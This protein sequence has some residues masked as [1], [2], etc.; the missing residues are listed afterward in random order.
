MSFLG[1]TYIQ[2]QVKSLDYH[3]K[4][5]SCCGCPANDQNALLQYKASHRIVAGRMIFHCW[6]F[7][8]ITL[9]EGR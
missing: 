9:E 3:Y 2:A 6:L 4:N 1:Q 8:V 7:S 5:H